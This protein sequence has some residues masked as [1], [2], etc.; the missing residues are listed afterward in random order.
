MK[1]I[2]VLGAGLVA[3]PLVDYLA[4]SD[5]L[6]LTVADIDVNKAEALTLDHSNASALQLDVNYQSEVDD[7]VTVRIQ[8]GA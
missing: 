2:L 7:L 8:E 4:T 5:G 3:K 1:R 6:E